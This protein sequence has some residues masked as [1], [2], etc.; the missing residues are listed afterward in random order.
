MPR[1]IITKGDIQEARAAAGESSL[2]EVDDGAPIGVAK[3]RESSRRSAAKTALE[4]TPD[5]YRDKLVKYIPAEVVALYLTL[6][7]ICRSNPTEGGLRWIILIFGCVVT[8][9]YLWRI[10]RVRKPI[11][12]VVSTAAFVVWTF[13]LGGPF[14][15]LSWYKAIYGAL[16]LPMFTFLVPLIDPGNEPNQLSDLEI[17]LLSSHIMRAPIHSSAWNSAM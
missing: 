7:V 17:L 14:V 13:A 2:D 16:L 11:Q 12:L 10:Q 8:P 9:L 6:D 1:T 4:I 15:S 3:P 5:S